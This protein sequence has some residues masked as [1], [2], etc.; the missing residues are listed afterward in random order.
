MRMLSLLGLITMAPMVAHAENSKWV[1]MWEGDLPAVYEKRLDAPFGQIV[2]RDSLFELEI[3][4]DAVT[5]SDSSGKT[6]FKVIGTG[7]ISVAEARVLYDEFGDGSVGG[8]IETIFFTKDG[9][10]ER[11]PGVDYVDYRV[12]QSH[13][14]CWPPPN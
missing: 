11:G 1:C 5:I 6:S 2:A 13:A 12:K 4:Q 8:N 9:I 10:M 14:R 7:K 3:G